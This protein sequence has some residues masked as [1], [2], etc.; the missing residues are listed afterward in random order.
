[1]DF[2]FSL[3]Q[4]LIA[5]SVR[6]ALEALPSCA[7]SEASAAKPLAKRFADLGLFAP[8]GADD[9]PLGAVDAVVVAIETGRLLPAAPA[10]EQLA[11]SLWLWPERPDLAVAMA[12][13]EVVTAAV[14]GTLACRDGALAGR[15]LVPFAGEAAAVLVPVASDDGRRWLALSPSDL[16]LS[17]ASTT[18]VTVEACWVEPSAT[19]GDRPLLSERPIAL[20]DLLSLLAMAEMVGAAEAGFART[21][22]HIGQRTQFGKPIGTYQAVK[23]MA[24][25]CASDLEV[26][27]A[28]VEYAGWAFDQAR[29][30]GQPA[31]DEAR[32]ALLTARSFVGE[33]ARLVPERC[34]QM[35]GGIAFTWDYGLHRHL[36]RIL[37]RTATLVRPMESRAAIAATM[38]S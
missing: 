24:A 35:H 7:A 8:P 4:Q 20:D 14:S 10:I 37:Y 3:E 27:K 25:D 36:R 5:R 26:M 13:G 18:D 1:M 38:L 31:L 9:P 15:V 22:E 23:H 29:D 30:G 17:P 28:A 2:D 21:I 33:R 12:D 6:G 11:A 19:L 34:I 16:M 32:M